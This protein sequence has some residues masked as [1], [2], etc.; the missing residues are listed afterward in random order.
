MT[1]ATH[2]RETPIKTVSTKVTVGFV[3]SQAPHF[4]DAGVPL[5]RGQNV[6]P[7]RLDMRNLK[8]IS[9]ET[10]TA[11]SK[12]ALQAGDVVIV[13]VGYPGVAAVIPPNTGRLNA[14]SLVIV[15]PDPAALDPHFLAY[16]LNS[17]WGRAAVAARLVG[18][19]QQVL[20][21]NAVADLEVRLPPLS[22][23]QRIVAP[24]RAIDELIDND[25]RR[26]Y[27][28]QEMARTIYREWFVHL[29][30]PG[31]ESTPVIESLIGRVPHGWRLSPFSDVANFVNGFAFKPSHW[32]TDGRPIIKIKELKQGVTS[33]TPR[34]AEELIDRKYWIEPGQLLFSWSADL[35]VYRWPGEPGL[36]NQHLFL[37]SPRAGLSIAFVHHA[38]DEAMPQF[39]DRAQGTTMRHIKRA[40]LDEVAI[41]VPPAQLVDAFTAAA[42]PLA[43]EVLRLQRSVRN[44][45]D[46]RSLLLPRLITG[47]ID[48]AQLDL[49]ALTAAAVT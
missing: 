42:E 20:N 38:L 1:D 10:H 19:A 6:R 11:W 46:L 2:W 13:R 48:A 32:G 31:H 43:Q 33:D 44:L 26:G 47:Q 7:W 9:A 17:P 27:V 16:L 35:G 39:W 49:D 30:F 28:L 45:A 40:A 22:L 23:Q 29:R 37:V 21:T 5:L 3:G 18:S 24:L 14:A 15:R 8:Y 34:C 4:V 12:S 36:L 25:R 41:M